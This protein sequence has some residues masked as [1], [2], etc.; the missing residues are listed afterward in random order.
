MFQAEQKCKSGWDRRYWW[1]FQ[2]IV[3][4]GNIFPCY[5]YHVRKIELRVR[6]R[7]TLNIM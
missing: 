5:D 7:R 2:R 4:R 1:R 3:G 6:V